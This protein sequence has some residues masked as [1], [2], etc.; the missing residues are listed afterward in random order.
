MSCP[1]CNNGFK[2]STKYASTVYDFRDKSIKILT[3]SEKNIVD[4]VGNNV[5]KAVE[6]LKDDNISDQLRWK[7]IQRLYKHFLGEYNG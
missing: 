7:I 2:T 6:I 3:L 1:M 4:I 5:D